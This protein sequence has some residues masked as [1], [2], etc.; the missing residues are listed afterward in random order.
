MTI[1]VPKGHGN[2]WIEMIKSMETNS[3]FVF[4]RPTTT[5]TGGARAFFIN[6]RDPQCT[7]K[8]LE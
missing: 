5:K 8:Y 7:R 6:Y 4:M 2:Q 1:E 3:D